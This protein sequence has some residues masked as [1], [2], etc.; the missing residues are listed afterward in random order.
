MSSEEGERG[1]R[2]G[3]DRKAGARERDAPA[4]QSRDRGGGF[5]AAREKARRRPISSSSSSDSQLSI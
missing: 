2:R 1:G 3:R 5:A 4:R